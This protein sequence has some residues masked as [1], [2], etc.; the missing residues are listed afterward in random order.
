MEITNTY[1]EDEIVIA[2]NRTAEKWF[3]IKRDWLLKLDQI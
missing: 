1:S 3:C 2:P